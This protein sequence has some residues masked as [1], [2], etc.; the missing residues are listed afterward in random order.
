MTTTTGRVVAAAATLVVSLFAAS[1]AH[2]AARDG[3]LLALHQPVLVFD[4]S[5]V[6]RPASVE[7]YLAD[8]DLEH[9]DGT[10]WTL[11]DANPSVADLP[12]TTPGA[13][14]LNQ[15]DCTPVAPLGGLPCYAAAANDGNDVSVVY[16]RVARAPGAIVLQYW[17]FYHDNTYSYA[18][19]PSNFIWQAHE[20]DWEVVNVVLSGQGEPLYAGYSQH[21]RGQR[22][23]WSATPRLGGH[24]R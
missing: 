8:A 2:A 14:R 23:A 9:L 13:W 7:S 6:F 15:D 22:R 19:P 16:A 12:A 5:D 24:L 1:A 4:R 10:T 17:L 11:A 21:C 20:G 3:Y 18:Y